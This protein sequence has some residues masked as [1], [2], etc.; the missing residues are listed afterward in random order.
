[1]FIPGPPYWISA[2]VSGCSNRISA[3]TLASAVATTTRAF[4]NAGAG[5][6]AIIWAFVGEA[7]VRA[8]VKEN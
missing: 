6:E 2:N 8:K 7:R 5:A 3:N 4:V 1:M